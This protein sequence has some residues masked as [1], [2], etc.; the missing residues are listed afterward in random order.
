M[1][2]AEKSGIRFLSTD[3]LLKNNIRTLPRVGSQR[4]AMILY[5][6]GTT[7]KPKGVLL[8]HNNLEAQITTL[9][10]AWEWRRD[11]HIMLVLP[12]H[13]THGIV[14]VLSCALWAG[15][16][17]E[18]LPAFDPDLV[19]QKI[20]GWKKHPVYGGADHLCEIDHGVGKFRA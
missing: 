2:V 4:P 14:N 5:T 3:R 16:A 11:D 18:M 12:L 10:K 7:G 13:H 9:V 8:T 17:C 6:S 19:W 20:P 1:P 15:A